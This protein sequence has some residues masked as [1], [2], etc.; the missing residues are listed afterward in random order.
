[1]ERER[2]RQ[3]SDEPF[4]DDPLADD[5]FGDEQVLQTYLAR[6]LDLQDQRD[7]FLEKADLDAAAKELGMTE[8][9]LARIKALVAA[10][11]QRG[12]GY[13]RN[14]R[15]NE[16]VEEYRQAVAL[17]PFDAPLTLAL[18]DAYRAR[19]EK[20][21]AADDRTEAARYARRAVELDPENQTAYRLLDALDRRLAAPAPTEAKRQL[22]MV[23]LFAMV[24]FLA[25]AVASGLWLIWGVL[26]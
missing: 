10:H 9:D 7:T 1:M 21:S 5:L 15:W 18:A 8:D 14:N 6:L 2:R 12:E 19:W 20:T 11:R 24:L 23:M 3:R 13:A 25:L 16:A 26:F 17:D 22:S 4:D